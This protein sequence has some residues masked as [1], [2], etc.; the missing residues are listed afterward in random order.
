[1]IN[2]MP[3]P[4]KFFPHKLQELKKLYA[5]HPLDHSW[6]SHIVGV[7]MNAQHICEVNLIQY[8]K[9]MEL[10]CAL[11]DCGEIYNRDKHNEIGARMVP[12]ILKEDLELDEDDVDIDLV[13]KCVLNHR[14]SHKGTLD[15]V[16]E[17]V[18]SAAD[19]MRPSITKEDLFKQVYLRSILYNIS[20]GPEEG[21]SADPVENSFNWVRKTY[22][23]EETGVY[24]EIYWKAFGAEMKI[25]KRLIE[26]V[27]LDELRAYAA[28][29]GIGAEITV[30]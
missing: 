12:S 13:A 28:T 2:S 5:N 16:D 7:I 15:T 23:D 29:Q 30:S 22:V 11:H 25:Q 4:L 20:H 27:T 8:T 19:R 18:V 17:Q 14:A 6:D 10:G 3:M 26:K 9:E 24:P 21:E 1:M